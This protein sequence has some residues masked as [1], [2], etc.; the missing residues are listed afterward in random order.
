MNKR[1]KN[2]TL[3][4]ACYDE[5]LEWK[6][7]EDF[8]GHDLP[9]PIVLINGAFDLLHASHM[10]VIFTARKKA[11]PRGTVVCAMDSDQAI[12]KVKGQNRPVMSWIE[13]ATAMSFM[14][15][16]LLCE[17]NSATEF[18]HLVK[19]LNPDLR[20]QGGDWM[21]K[22]SRHPSIPKLFVRETELHT[23]AIIQRIYERQP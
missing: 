3:S 6:R 20:V 8:I 17:I 16:D 5:E 4:R 2:Y 12:K 19:A 10:R 18:N 1:Y 15:V 13:R 11:G 14:P 7:V 23:T 22:P 21:G 9:R